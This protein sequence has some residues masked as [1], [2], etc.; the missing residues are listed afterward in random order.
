MQYPK[1]IKESI[2]MFFKTLKLSF[3]NA[4]IQNS[5]IQNIN[6]MHRFF[7]M[8][9]LP[10]L[11]VIFFTYSCNA[12]Y[13][14]Q[15]RRLITSAYSSDMNKFLQS[16]EDEFSNIAGEVS[17]LVSLPAINTIS[18]T[19]DPMSITP[20]I[21]QSA[22]TSLY[23]FAN[24]MNY[25]DNIIII[26][27]SGNFVFSRDGIFSIDEY[28][29][30]NSGYTDYDAEY[31]RNYRGTPGSHSILTPTSITDSSTSETKN[32]IPVVYPVIGEGGNSLFV[33]N[34]GTAKLYD[35]FVN[36]KFTKNS[37]LFMVDN[38]TGEIYS[39]NTEATAYDIPDISK[40]DLVSETNYYRVSNLKSNGSKY[41]V[42]SSQNRYGTF[43]YTFVGVV[44]Y[45]DINIQSHKILIHILFLAV[46]IILLML[47]YA[48]IGSVKLIKP[49]KNIAEKL[50]KTEKSRILDQNPVETQ[51]ETS[52]TDLKSAKKNKKVKK[53]KND[54]VISFVNDAITVLLDQNSDLSHTVAV[55]LPKSQEKYLVDIL[56]NPASDYNEAM[57]SLIFK[58]EYFVSIA[59][60]ISLKQTAGSDVIALNP[61]LYSEVYK[62][63]ES[64]FAAKF[65]TFSLPST[66]NTL[67][68]ILNV[69]SDNCGSDLDETI[70]QI[71]SLLA[72]DTDYIDVFIGKGKIY[73]GIDGLRLSHQEAMADIFHD[74]NSD[75]IQIVDNHNLHEYSF[76][77]YNENILINYILTG[78]SA[79]AVSFIKDTFESCSKSSPENRS[80]VYAGIYRAIGKVIKVKKIRTFDF[81][82]KAESV[83][84]E[85]ILNTSDD[86]VMNYLI[87]LTE[88][89]SNL[90]TPGGKAR[91]AEIADYIKENYSED[92]CLD[93]LAQRFNVTPKYLSK[94][95]KEHLGISFK[96]YLTSLRIDKAEE[97]LK[98]KDIKIN[99]ICKMV[100]FMNH[101]AFIRAFKLKNGISPSEYRT[102]YHK[103]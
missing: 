59:I 1:K 3:K 38:A 16:T 81:E 21:I 45:S 47:L 34:T 84:L 41:F 33:F 65:T 37:K 20:D 46:V 73:K 77:V 83:I 39:G 13:S 23:S 52:E 32:V 95:L 92:L 91:I 35:S 36:Y 4:D 56:N 97:L 61:Q 49:W 74:M 27:R 54:D 14:N 80:Q 57:D 28:F 69:E 9:C 17:D 40:S 6:I 99:E 26:N 68:L 72:A 62:A 85:D 51:D 87:S 15:Y 19:S 50:S 60:N 5:S 44:P 90:E 100:G 2:S 96:V 58:H 78:R 30:G 8:L 25:A 24:R 63:I 86:S 29:A 79:E 75:K 89:I 55:T 31:W 101:S 70:E 10:I 71:N 93:N 64:V 67:Y 42:L 66:N 43:G 98:N 103:K 22:Q 76:G 94:V 18:Y 82:I 12:C 88:N 11:I 7:L 48:Y 102:L 53:S